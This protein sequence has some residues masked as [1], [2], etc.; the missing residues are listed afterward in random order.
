[1]NV[2]AQRTPIMT[3]V[4][5][6]HMGLKE[7]NSWKL[8]PYRALNLRLRRVDGS[9]EMDS[10]TFASLL[11]LIEGRVNSCRAGRP[12]NN[13]PGSSISLRIRRDEI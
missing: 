4:S 11:P 2:K 3:F 6:V 9:R 5:W 10:A 12:P 8:N 13:G 1:M 7:H